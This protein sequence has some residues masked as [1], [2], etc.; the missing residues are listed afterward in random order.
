MS[1]DTP[2]RWISDEEDTS[3]HTRY[4]DVGNVRLHV[5]IHKEGPPLLLIG[6]IGANMDMWAPFVDA[7]T[8]AQMI[9]FD[10]PGTGSS[11]GPRR[12]RRFPTLATIVEGLLDS[13]GHDRVDVLGVSWGGGLAQQL[14][15][16]APHRVRRLVLAATSW[17]FGSLPGRPLAMMF[18]ATPA[19][20]YSQRFFRLAAP[21]MFGGEQWK[22]EHWTREHTAARTAHPPTLTGYYAHA[23][24]GM[25]WSS[26]PWVHTLR[27]PTLVLSGDDD[28][29]VPALNGKCLAARIP[30]ARFHMIRGG[31][32]LFVLEKPHEVAAVVSRF[33]HQETRVRHLR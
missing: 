1:D 32:H 24:A 2:F 29:V 20:Y 27:Q 22:N 9:L 17:G 14:A 13:L 19:R 16:Q 18:M 10:I 6:G 8:G 33:L 31:G 23:L 30:N 3:G 12:F 11:Y 15:H 4:V 25:T 5:A 21:F 26:L 7:M 28:P